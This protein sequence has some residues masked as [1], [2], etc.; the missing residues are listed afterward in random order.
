MRLDEIKKTAASTIYIEVTATPQAVILQSEMSGWKPDFIYYF[1]PGEKYLG[2]NYFY[3]KTKSF[4][5]INTPN[6]E[7]DDILSGDDIICPIGLQRSILSFLINCAHKKLNRESNCNFMIHPSYKIDIHNT[8]VSVVQNHLNLL[9]KATEEDAF[10]ENL[11]DEWSNLQ[12]TKPDLE[13]F[14]DIKDT[15]I[16][17]LENTE[18]IVIPL[19][20]QSFICRDPKDPNAL[21]LSKGFNIVIGGNT[22]GRGITFPNLQTVYYCRTSRAPQA[23]TFWQHSRIFGYDREKQMVH[24]F[25]PQ[26]LYKLFSDINSSNEMLINQIESDYEHIQLIYPNNIKPTRSNVV[27]N[28]HLNLLYGGINIFSSTATTENI[29]KIN[30]LIE[31]Y[32]KHQS[33]DTD[34]EQI[35]KILKLVT[36]ESNEDFDTQKFIACI[37]G[38]KVQRP[39]IKCKLIVRT[40]RNIAKDTGT[41]LSP[42]DRILGD[43]FKKE[44]VLTMYRITG[45]KD[46]GWNGEPLWIPNIKFPN[47]CCFYSMS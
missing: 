34:T 27:D 9:T 23:D 28:K 44:I 10:I 8:F 42:N 47:D 38:L 19:N 3:P 7:L 14:D 35:E 39:L 26:I 20:S 25:I 2:G 33:V 12:E 30:S 4:T 46:K 5:T 31:D 18:I 40:N 15:V 29:E 13:N 6:Y 36:C 37:N 32:S 24:I 41:L 22:L 11:K 1:K 16:E 17:I 43:S 21:D 45:N